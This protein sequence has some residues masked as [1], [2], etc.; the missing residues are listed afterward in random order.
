MLEIL[1]KILGGGNAIDYKVLLSKGALIVDVR[2]PAEFK[3][4]HIKGSLNIPLDRVKTKAAE[5]KRKNKP[6]I[7]CCRGGNRSGMAKGILIS[8]GIECYNGGAW[9]E[10]NH[11]IS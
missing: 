3:S 6:I 4:G 8:A 5:L 10:L 11:K 9:N 7:T 1:K 2:T